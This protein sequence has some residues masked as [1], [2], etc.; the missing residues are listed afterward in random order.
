MYVDGN[1]NNLKSVKE[2]SFIVIIIFR[3][4]FFSFFNFFYF[5][6]LFLLLVSFAWVSKMKVVL[7]SVNV[8]WNKWWCGSSAR[9]CLHSAGW[10]LSVFHAEWSSCCGLNRAQLFHKAQTHWGSFCFWRA[11]EVQGLW[12]SFAWFHLGVSFRAHEIFMIVII[13]RLVQSALWSHCRSK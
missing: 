2:N 3:K 13:T 6:L 1:Q 11:G 10:F 4:F 5:L 8:A 12:K 9:S 7:W